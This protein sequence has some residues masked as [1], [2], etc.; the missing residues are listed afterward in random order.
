MKKIVMALAVIA[1]VACFSSC[2]KTCSCTYKLLGISY[3]TEISKEDLGVKFCSE[4]N[5]TGINIGGVNIADA[6]CE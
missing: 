3:T 2:K 4:A 6:N 1:M 5:K